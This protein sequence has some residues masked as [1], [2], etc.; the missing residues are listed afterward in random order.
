MI[1]DFG[2]VS[3]CHLRARYAP[4][5]HALLVLLTLGERTVSREIPLGKLAVEQGITAD[6]LATC[7]KVYDDVTHG[8]VEDVEVVP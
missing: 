3:G 8:R 2:V 7:A 1:S 6:E 4:R 5:R